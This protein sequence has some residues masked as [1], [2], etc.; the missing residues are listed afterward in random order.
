MII[1]GS[2]TSISIHAPREGERRDRGKRPR[3]RRGISIHAPREGERRQLVTQRGGDIR[4]SIH[5]PREGERQRLY[6]GEFEDKAISIHAP[7]EGERPLS[8]SVY[9]ATKPSISIHAPREGERP[10]MSISV[11]TYADFNPRSPR[12]GATPPKP[13]VFPH[14]LISIHAPREGERRA[15]ISPI[16][17]MSIS[18][19]APREGERLLRPRLAK[20]LTRF[21]STL[22]ARGSD[23][24]RIA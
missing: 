2:G 9:V 17:P 24:K 6:N 22:P 20:G 14:P 12:G 19:H 3:L 5:A 16:L 1:S 11:Y 21:Q 18:I 8:S 7:R 4:I 13:V 15:P 23:A 10:D